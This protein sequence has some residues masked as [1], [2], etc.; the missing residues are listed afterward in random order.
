MLEQSHHLSLLSAAAAALKRTRFIPY[1]CLKTYESSSRDGAGRP[2]RILWLRW[3]LRLFL[4]ERVWTHKVLVCCFCSGALKPNSTPP[5]HCNHSPGVSLPS[6]S[7]CY[8]ERMLKHKKKSPLN[9]RFL[10]FLWNIC[11]SR[12]DQSGGK[13]Q[14]LKTQTSVI[15][16]EDETKAAF[17]FIL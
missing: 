11:W 8:S 12:S 10:N 17:I 16:T 4:M 9:L 5:P 14:I 6:S 3:T 13:G 15:G 7:A 2:Q 1:D